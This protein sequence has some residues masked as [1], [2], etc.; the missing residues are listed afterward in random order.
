MSTLTKQTLSHLDW[1][2]AEAIHILREVA[3]QCANPVLLFSGGKD[4]ICL[5]RLAEKAFRPGR[6]PFPLMHIDTGHNY[7]EVTDFRD[8]RAAELGERLIVR[9]VE[10]S[11]A[12][13]TVV[14][15]HP[16]E[17]RN[18]HQSVTLLEA[19]EEFGFDACIGGARRDEEK[20]R[21]KERIMSF[22]DEFGQWDPKNQ[23]PELWNL[24]NARSHKGENIRAFPISNWTELDV[25]QYIQREQL[26][27]PSIYFAHVR[28]V[29]RKSGLLQPVTELTPAKDGDVVEEVLVRFRTVGDITCTA[30]VESDADTVEKILAE[31]A[32]TT[33]T[34][35]GATRMDDQTSEASMEQ[36]KKEGY[37]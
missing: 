10:D 22:R 25:W 13:G 33:I 37:F 8:K 5:L 4:S 32:T 36:R 19:I 20:A 3:G 34:E 18:K 28:P 17:S 9:S 24:Y 7:K 26:E 2:E 1:L 30:P 27:L 11:M 29:V 12:R 14:L 21:A 31:T 16:G 23:R 35:R 15:K 6:F